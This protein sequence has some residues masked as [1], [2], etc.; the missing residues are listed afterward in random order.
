[1]LDNQ[2]FTFEADI[3]VACLALQIV[4]ADGYLAAAAGGWRS[5]DWRIDLGE[6][7]R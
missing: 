7:D 1:M 5:H 3:S 6:L 4:D 2:A